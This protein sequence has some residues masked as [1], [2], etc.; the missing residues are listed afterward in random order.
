MVTISDI[1]IGSK[2]MVRGCFGMDE[3]VEARVTE[4]FEKIKNGKPGICYNKSWAY[5]N[6]VVQVLEY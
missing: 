5:L 2:V 1:Q 3:P 6:Q 4:V